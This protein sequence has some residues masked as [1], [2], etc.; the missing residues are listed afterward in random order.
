MIRQKVFSTNST[1][2]NCTQRG[3]CHSAKSAGRLC[4]TN[5]T[6]TLHVRMDRHCENAMSVAEHLS[7][8]DKVARVIYPGLESHDDFARASELFD[9]LGGVMSFELEDSAESSVGAEAL[10]ARLRIVPRAISFGGCESLVCLPSKTSHS[11]VTAEERAAA[12]VSPGLIRL[13]VGIE[14]IDDLLEDFDQALR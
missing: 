13:S 14:S 6:K 8:H 4:Y 5:G 11:S 2:A 1:V 9:G 3:S 7:A 10:L 12:G